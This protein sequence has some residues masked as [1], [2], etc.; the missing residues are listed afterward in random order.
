MSSTAR[1]PQSPDGLRESLQFHSFLCCEAQLRS[2]SSFSNKEFLIEEFVQLK[3]HVSEK[4]SGRNLSSMLCVAA[5]TV[6]DVTCRPYKNK[7]MKRIP[8]HLV[9]AVL[10]YR[11]EEVE[12][13][14]HVGCARPCQGVIQAGDISSFPLI[15]IYQSMHAHRQVAEHLLGQALHVCLSPTDLPT[16]FA[17]RGN[18]AIKLKAAK[19]FWKKGTESKKQKQV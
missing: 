15:P 12:I 13:H 16:A 2:L 7:R 10:Y 4:I 5:C 8:R 19:L 1:P 6:R 9:W 11:F 3:H 17:A 14:C 18:E